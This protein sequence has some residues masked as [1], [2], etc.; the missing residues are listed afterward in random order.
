MNQIGSQKQAVNN[1]INLLES[2]LQTSNDKDNM[3]KTCYQKAE[4]LLQQNADNSVYALLVHEEKDR[5]YVIV[6][7]QEFVQLNENKEY[8]QIIIDQNKEDSTDYLQMINQ[9]TEDKCVLGVIHPGNVDSDH[10][11]FIRNE[12]ND[13]QATGLELT[14]YYGVSVIIICLL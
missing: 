4:N 14:K 5:D 2:E 12:D 8:L 11:Q 3:D 7:Q 6:G 13:F 10:L 1:E 9:S